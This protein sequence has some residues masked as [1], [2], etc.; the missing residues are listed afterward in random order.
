LGIEV[1]A[2]AQREQR[3]ATL[4]E[5]GQG[6]TRGQGSG[7]RCVSRDQGS[8]FRVQSSV[9]TSNSFSAKL[10]P[11]RSV[12]SAVHHWLRVSGAWFRGFRFEV[13]ET[14]FRDWGLGLCLEVWGPEHCVARNTGFER[15]RGL[16]LHRDGQSSPKPSDPMAHVI[17]GARCGWVW[18]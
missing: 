4:F 7:F 6:L 8:G 9:Y 13:W 15:G 17:W 10:P 3:R 18:G 5:R 16:T 1:A 12:R 2:L 14:R 11:L